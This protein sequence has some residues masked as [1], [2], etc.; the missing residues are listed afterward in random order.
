MAI[1]NLI[2]L[3]VKMIEDQ[4]Q[5]IVCLWEETYCHGEARNKLLCLDQQ[6]KLNI[7]LYP[8]G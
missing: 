1:V 6:L 3:V 8:K 2:G 4:C 7:E 5:A